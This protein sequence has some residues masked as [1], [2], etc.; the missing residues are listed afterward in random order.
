MGLVG[1][2]QCS[3]F[4]RSA[5]RMSQAEKVTAPEG[6]I[7]G[8]SRSGVVGAHRSFSERSSLTPT[9]PPKERWLPCPLM[10]SIMRSAVNQGSI[11]LDRLSLPE[12]IYWI[13]RSKWAF[14][15]FSGGF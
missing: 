14:F 11:S 6:G 4:R 13:P 5:G 3:R 15:L 9:S 1:G 10:G 2:A 7:P 12:T 8:L